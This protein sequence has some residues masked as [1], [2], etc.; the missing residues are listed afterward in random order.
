MTLTDVLRGEHGLLYRLF[1]HL[2]GRLLV[3]GPDDARRAACLL[4][5]VLL[6]HA[7]VEDDLLF[8]VLEPVIGPDGPLAVMRMEHD[9]I[10]DGVRDLID[11]RT[12]SAPQE[13]LL[14]ILS[15]ARGHFA[16]E[17][18][19]LFPLAERTLGRSKLEELGRRWAEQRGVSVP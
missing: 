6:S 8:A 19:V 15:L 17:E 11:G 14:E 9:A 5:E 4:D 7:H 10:H 12:S 1:G 16:K 3:E 13:R 18:A 2:E